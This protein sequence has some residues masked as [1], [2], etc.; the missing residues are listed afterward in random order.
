MVSPR[1]EDVVYIVDVIMCSEEVTPGNQTLCCDF[2]LTS[3]II[4]DKYL[5]ST[6]SRKRNNKTQLN[7]V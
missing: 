6:V 2:I 3:I 1:C 5:L 4:T 7:I